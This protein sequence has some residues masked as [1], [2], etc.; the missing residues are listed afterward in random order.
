MVVGS[1]QWG[2]VVAVEEGD[3]RSVFYSCPGQL[4]LTVANWL[5]SLTR[6]MERGKEVR[7]QRLRGEGDGGGNLKGFEGGG[8]V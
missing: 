7:G 1:V 6:E 8:G 4:V 5:D 2:R 3:A